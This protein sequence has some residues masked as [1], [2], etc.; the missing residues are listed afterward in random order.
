MDKEEMQYL[1]R[2]G[3]VARARQYLFGQRL[4]LREGRYHI[5]CINSEGLR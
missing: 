4:K 3:Y 1:D 2:S 5:V